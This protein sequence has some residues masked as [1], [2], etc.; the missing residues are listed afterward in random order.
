MLFVKAYATHTG[1]QKMTR[2]GTTAGANTANSAAQKM[3][4]KKV[5]K[6]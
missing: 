2:K 1:G 3:T 5:T 4:R 6:A